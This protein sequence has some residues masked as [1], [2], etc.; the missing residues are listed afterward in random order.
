M[1]RQ[2]R[3]YV[4]WRMAMQIRKLNEDETAQLGRGYRQLVEF[5]HQSELDAESLLGILFKA[6]MG[7]AV[8]AEYD[9]DEILAVVSA[10]YD[11]ER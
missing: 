8:S 11:M 6:A 1:K 7:L 3:W 10:T 2:K 5:M 4:I 9:R